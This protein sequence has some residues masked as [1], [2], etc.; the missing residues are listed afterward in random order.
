MKK[1]FYTSGALVILF[2]ILFSTGILDYK[3]T[4]IEALVKGNAQY[5][6]G[7][8]EKALEFYAEGIQKK[9]EDKKTQFQF[10]TGIVSLERI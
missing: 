6:A 4:G 10:R 7:N 3:N 9:P 1:V 5:A 2:L 8:Y